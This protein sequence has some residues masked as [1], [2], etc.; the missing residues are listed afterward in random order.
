[1]DR[2]A[3]L[4]TPVRVLLSEHPSLARLL[5]E[6]GVHCGEC[7]IADRDTLA[8]VAIMHQLNPGALLDE[9]AQRESLPD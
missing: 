7:F 3:L 5:E 2:E 1:M 6:H 9:W 4:R 8:Q